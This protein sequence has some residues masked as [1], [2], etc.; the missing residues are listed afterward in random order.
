MML[1]I[2]VLDRYFEENPTEMTHL[3]HDGELRT[4]RQQAHLKHVP[5]YLLPKE[6][7]QGIAAGDIG[8]VPLKKHD[9]RAGTKRKG[10]GKR[11]EHVKRRLFFLFCFCLLY[12]C[13]VFVLCWM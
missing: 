13:W 7:R 11:K 9:R 12:A 4:A 8:F 6:G 1:I 5:D 10:G 3:R 2:F